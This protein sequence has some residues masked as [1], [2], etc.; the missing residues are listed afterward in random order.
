MVGRPVPLAAEVRG[1]G[2]TA[3]ASAWCWQSPPPPASCE[4]HSR[5]FASAFLSRNGR[6]RR[7]VLPRKRGRQRRVAR[8]STLQ[9]AS[10]FHRPPLEREQAAR[11]FLN[12]QDDEHQD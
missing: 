2:L 1:G 10:C 12:E 8:R 9:A 6:R 7:P 4:R 11:A 5:S 3:T